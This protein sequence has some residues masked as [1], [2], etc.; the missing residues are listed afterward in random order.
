MKAIW[1]EFALLVTQANNE[2]QKL[3]VT[4]ALQRVHNHAYNCVSICPAA[5]EQ[6]IT[7]DHRR[8]EQEIA[9]TRSERALQIAISQEPPISI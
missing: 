7:D 4:S 8:A 5:I 6:M 2:S 3:L 9:H 1:K